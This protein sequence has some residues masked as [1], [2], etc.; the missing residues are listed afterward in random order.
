M[1]KTEVY[2][3]KRL[4]SLVLMA[5]LAAGLAGC[6][7]Q[8]RTDGT[9]E[10]VA[11]PQPVG[12]AENAAT[13]VAGDF[14]AISSMIGVDTLFNAGDRFY[15]L[16]PRSGYCL[17]YRID[18]DTA[19][20]GVLCSL[21]GCTHDSAGCPAWLPGQIWDY[22]TFATEDTVYVYKARSEEEV[23]D[24]DSYYQQNVAPYLNDEDMLQGR[25]P[26]EFETY[27]R[28]WFDQLR[29]P[30]CLYAVAR[31]G[32]A[33]RRIDL[34]ENLERN[35]LLSWCDGAALYGCPPLTAWDAP[36]QGYRVDLT[37]GQVTTFD[38]LPGESILAAGGRRLLTARMVSEVPF[39]DQQ[40]EW[41]ACQAILQNATEECVWLDPATGQ[42]EKLLELPGSLI[43]QG[44]NFCGIA[45]EQLYFFER[46]MQSEGA[47][48]TAILA[49][50]TATGQQQDL[51][52]PLP[53]ESTWLNDPTVVGLPDIAEQEGRYLWFVYS[54]ANGSQHMQILDRTSGTMYDPPL[55]TQ[56]V[57]FQQSKGRLPLT[58]DGRFLLCA[59]QES[60]AFYDYKYALID[61]EAF[62][63]GSTDYTLVTTQEE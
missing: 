52:R 63:Q 39:S 13:P 61:A 7:G 31:D 38:L 32:S 57:Q 2:G 41:E 36:M 56:Q 10:T 21:P 28:N 16:R 1:Q 8:P 29:Q 19:T 22:T 62:L 51:L 58:D 47:V 5:V 26:Q 50:D 18:C 44:G 46:Q 48:P 14:Y 35:T 45:G 11:T 43:T 4:L 34:S 42:R 3:M 25:T 49:F 20:R 54:G 24:W 59:E 23:T 27:Y 33:R 60:G 37:T 9:P 53:R 30:A 55:T 12:T 6:G 15:E 17:L 40:T